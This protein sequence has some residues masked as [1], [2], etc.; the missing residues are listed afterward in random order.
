VYRSLSTNREA[1][2]E[3][4]AT[5]SKRIGRCDSARTEPRVRGGRHSLL[6]LFAADIV[7]FNMKII[8]RFVLRFAE[9]ST[10]TERVDQC[11]VWLG[12]E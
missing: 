7:G 1:R 12:I 4:R 8:D 9:A 6:C 3:V 5:D 2:K 11:N 10:E